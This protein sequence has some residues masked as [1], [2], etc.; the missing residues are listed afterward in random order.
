MLHAGM[1][2]TAFGTTQTQFANCQ[3][4]LSD[5]ETGKQNFLV[6]VLLSGQ[7]CA[8]LCK[9]SYLLAALG[10][11]KPQDSLWIIPGNVGE[12][13]NICFTS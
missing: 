8:K 10:N 9:F 13:R 1:R 7:C 6:A 4:T 2:K 3:L 5:G 12:M 11:V